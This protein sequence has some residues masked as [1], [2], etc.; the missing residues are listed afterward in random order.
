MNWL[1]T[2]DDEFHPVAAADAVYEAMKEFGAGQSEANGFSKEDDSYKTFSVIVAEG[3]NA[4]VAIHVN[5]KT[6][7]VVTAWR[8]DQEQ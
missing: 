7:E 6:Q 1:P 2:T 5:W 4:V 8:V 3:P